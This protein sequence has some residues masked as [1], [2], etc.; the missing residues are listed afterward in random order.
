MLSDPRQA[1]AA[2]VHPRPT[3]PQAVVFDLGGVL[4]DWNPRYVYRDMGGSE[5]EIEHFLA[6]VAPPSWNE[7]MDAGRP[8]AEAVAERIADHP[9]HADWLRAYH[10][11]WEDMLGGPMP[12]TVAVLADLRARA[13]PLYALTNWS[14]ETF[15]TALRLYDFLGWF[16]GIVV[17][18]EKKVVKPDPAIFDHLR[19]DFG[20]EPE[21]SVFI[22]DNLL[23]VEAARRLG[24]HGIHFQD[25]AAL[26]AELEALGLLPG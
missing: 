24:F 6:H 23:N 22:D 14:A 4:I 18:G 2:G 15:P 20:V 19:T 1:R 9:G 7:Q 5:A 8:F 12:E 25:A 3:P 13:V 17:S 26:R 21:G 16:A 11:R 10:E